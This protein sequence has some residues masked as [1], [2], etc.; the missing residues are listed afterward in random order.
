MNQSKPNTI[1]KRKTKQYRRI[2]NPKK[3]SQVA[4][5]RLH[6]VFMIFYVFFLDMFG[7]TFMYL[8]HDHTN[9]F[10]IYVLSLS[11]SMAFRLSPP[12]PCCVFGRFLI[13]RGGRGNLIFVDGQLKLTVLA[14]S[15]FQFIS[16]CKKYYMHIAYWSK[17]QKQ[18]RNYILGH[19]SEYLQTRKKHGKQSGQTCITSMTRCTPK[20]YLS[21]NLP[22]TSKKFGWE[23]NCTACHCFTSEINWLYFTIPFS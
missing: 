11:L 8:C 10:R 17:V 1:S 5:C 14:S 4:F 21:K 13:T 20:K 6:V 7:A 2:D 23:P 12:Q 18:K 22:S 16:S 9:H 15:H 3:A 19:A